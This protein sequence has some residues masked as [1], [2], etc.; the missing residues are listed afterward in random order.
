MMK[1][2]KLAADLRLEKIPAR[3][4]TIFDDA[5]AH[6]TP[7]LEEAWLRDLAGRYPVLT[8]SMEDCLKAAAQIKIIEPLR[9]FCA[10]LSFAMQQ[11]KDFLYDCAELELPKAG[12]DEDETAYVMAAYLSSLESVPMAAEAY[13]KRGVPDDILQATLEGIEGSLR[14]YEKRFGRLGM[15]MRYLGWNQR[16]FDQRLLRIG[17]LNFDVFHRMGGNVALFRSKSGRQQLLAV[18]GRYDREGFALGSAGHENEEGAFDAVYEEAERYYGGYAVDPR[19][20]VTKTF[21]KLDKAGWEKAFCPEDACIFVHIP[22]GPG[23]TP[24]NVG[25]CIDKARKIIADGYPDYDVKGFCCSS[26]LMDPQLGDILGDEANITRFQRRFLRAPQKSQG[27]DV[28]T[29]LYPKAVES[30]DQLPENTRLERAVKKL[31]LNGQYIYEL[32]GLFL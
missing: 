22:A 28:F 32:R 25:S 12:A 19:G 30:Y 11:R 4:E 24:E 9:T 6:G 18:D 3:W 31:Y 21:M 10:L 7:F 27:R 13:A 29:F 2:A 14:A 23:L 20:R 8:F 5:I 26:W 1:L 17:R 15:D 16:Y